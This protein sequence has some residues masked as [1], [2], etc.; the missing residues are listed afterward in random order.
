MQ[1]TLSRLNLLPIFLFYLVSCNSGPTNNKGGQLKTDT[2]HKD[3]T[4]VNKAITNSLGFIHPTRLTPSQF[5]SLVKST[6]FSD[7]LYFL[8]VIDDFP[9]YWVTKSHIDTLMTLI[10]SNE[11]CGCIVNPLS[12]F[13]PNERAD[14]GG[15]AIK[16]VNSF[17][18]KQKLSF[19]LWACPRTNK[20]E[21]NVLIEWWK[22]QTK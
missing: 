9:N 21:V 3:L 17:R 16:L 19:G 4:D 12:S 7:T 13:I 2:N 22:T 20:K 18:T 10:N 14:V 8:T 11:K 1:M 15:Y 5:L 6:H